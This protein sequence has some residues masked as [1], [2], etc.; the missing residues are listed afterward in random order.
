MH[1][2]AE[3]LK[4]EVVAA[5]SGFNDDRDSLDFDI[6]GPLAELPS[7]VLDTFIS[8]P[9]DVA[10]GDDTPL[11]VPSN[12]LFTAMISDVTQEASRIMSKVSKISTATLLKKA[13]L[14]AKNKIEKQKKQLELLKKLPESITKERIL[15]AVKSGNLLALFSNPSN[16]NKDK[17]SIYNKD[18]YEAKVAE[19][20][21]QL[22]EIERQC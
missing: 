5:R 16:E 21:P 1:K 6:F 4:A 3:I 14:A 20:L 11:S 12:N 10:R 8:I 19:I 2:S 18:E 13:E 17:K 9:E 15:E 7:A 22:I